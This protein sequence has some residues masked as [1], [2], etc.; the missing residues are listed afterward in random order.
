MQLPVMDPAQRYGEFVT[1]LAPKGARFGIAQMM[2]V[3]WCS[4]AQEARFGRDILQVPL[5]APRASLGDREF[6][7][8][9][10]LGPLIGGRGNLGVS[11]G[12]RSPG[13]CRSCA[14]GDERS[15]V[16]HLGLGYAR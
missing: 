12:F 13:F 9:N 6:L 16:G 4:P 10:P 7:N 5:V 1:H 8:G 11:P 3:R 2:C 14:A 15:K